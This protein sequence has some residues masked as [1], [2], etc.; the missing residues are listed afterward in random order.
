MARARTDDRRP[1]WWKV[2]LLPLLLIGAGS[3]V[4]FFA[5]RENQRLWREREATERAERET[6]RRQLERAGFDET[7]ALCAAGWRDQLGFHHQPSALAW[8]RRGLDGYFVAGT[9]LRSLR[10]LRCDERGVRR[11]PRVAHPLLAESAEATPEAGLDPDSDGGA[12]W[13]LALGR[14]AEASRDADELGVELIGH[15]LTGA[16]LMRRWR[17]AEGGATPQLEPP[18]AP[19]FALLIADAGFPF[20]PGAAPPA[21]QPLTR[22]NW[23]AQPEAAFDVVAR[24][25]PRGAR[26]AEL[27]LDADA[28]T[29]SIEHPTPAFDGNPPAPYGDLEFDEYGV[30]ERDWFYP[31]TDPGFGCR[32][33]IPLA[34]LRERYFVA[35]RSVYGTLHRAWYSCSPA[36]SNGRRGTWHL[37]DDRPAPD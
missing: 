34:E 37:V 22:S 15:P 23:L 21:L 13:H 5:Q 25:L 9:H 7:L 3:G 11:G 26:V 18:D 33:G 32:Q 20:A 24:A 30:A 28:I 4:A 36:Y 1:R 35:T 2:L 10:Q 16:V 17:G 14:L 8:T 19:P 27:T 31:R 12:A 29:L 6:R